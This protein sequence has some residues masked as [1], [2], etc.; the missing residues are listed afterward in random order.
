MTICSVFKFSD[1]EL[2][3]LK[4]SNLFK[5]RGKY[6]SNAIPIGKGCTLFRNHET[7]AFTKHTQ[8][9]DLQRG[10]SV[11]INAANNLAMFELYFY[12]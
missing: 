1:R 12:D 7:T 9:G 8:S 11:R 5:Y 3:Q 10:Y 4:K 6:L 2:V